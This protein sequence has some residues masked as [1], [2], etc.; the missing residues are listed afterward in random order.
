MYALYKAKCATEGCE[1]MAEI[2]YRD[3]FNNDFNLAFNKPKR[4][5]CA[6]CI[7]FTS[8]PEAEKAVQQQDYLEHIYRKKE[9]RMVKDK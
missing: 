6:Y 5:A 9:A 3:I 2:L 8:M 4:D 1:P 7:K